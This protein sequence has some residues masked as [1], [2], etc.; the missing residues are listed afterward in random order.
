MAA[1]RWTFQPVGWADS[2]NPESAPLPS[3]PIPPPRSPQDQHHWG[4]GRQQLLSPSR[5]A[6][7]SRVWAKISILP[8][9]FKEPGALARTLTWWF[10]CVGP[11]EL[12][13]GGGGGVQRCCQSGWSLASPSAHCHMGVRKLRLFRPSFISSFFWALNIRTKWWFFS[14]QCSLENVVL[15]VDERAKMRKKEIKGGPTCLSHHWAKVL[16]RIATSSCRGHSKTR[17][18]V[19]SN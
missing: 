16:T 8:P 4:P 2:W 10:F 19:K 12:C 13:W 6:E 3:I 5:P 11:L 17:R 9:K 1:E 7:L 15:G 18:L 14:I